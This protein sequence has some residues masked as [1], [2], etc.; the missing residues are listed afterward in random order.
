MFNPLVIGS[1]MELVSKKSLRNNEERIVYAS[2]I[3]D[4]ND[5]SI[6]CAM[7]IYE[8]R[9]VPLEACLLYT[10]PSTRDGLLSRVPSSA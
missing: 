4:F 6:V 9:I 5:D 8:G 7:P 1:R 2:Q 10:S 3:L